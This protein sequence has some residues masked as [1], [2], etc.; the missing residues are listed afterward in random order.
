MNKLQM[1]KWFSYAWSHS[2]WNI[3]KAQSVMLSVLTKHFSLC[4]TELVAVIIF[5]AFDF[6]KCAHVE[7]CFD[8]IWVQYTAGSSFW[9]LCATAEY[10]GLQT[11]FKLE[12]SLTGGIRSILLSRSVQSCF[13]RCTG[14]YSFLLHLNFL[15]TLYLQ[16]ELH[17]DG[18]SNIVLV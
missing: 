11:S 18:A 12:V 15:Q 2:D 3:M 5:I 10:H 9:D 7:R 13:D 8:G 6:L 17:K 14:V 1:A 16:W 4:P